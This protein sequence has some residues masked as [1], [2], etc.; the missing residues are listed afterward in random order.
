VFKAT[1]AAQEHTSYTGT[2][3]NLTAKTGE[4]GTVKAAGLVTTGTT[5]SSTAGKLNCT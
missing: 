4:S 3:Y 2:K 1:G 5:E